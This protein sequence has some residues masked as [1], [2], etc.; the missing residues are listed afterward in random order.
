MTY[1]KWKIDKQLLKN[2]YLVLLGV[3][4]F[5]ILGQH[6]VINILHLPFSFMELYFIP[7]II[8][9]RKQVTKTIK[10]MGKV[11]IYTA[12]LY[13]LLVTGLLFGI[14]TTF[15]FN[16]L[17]AY[18]SILYLFFC[19]KYVQTGNFS[20]TPCTV[21]KVAI[22]AM[23]GEFI[24]ILFFATGKI[25]SSTNCVAIATAI[26]AAFLL[27]KYVVA[28]LCTAFG[29]ILS[30]TTGFRIGIVVVGVC[31]IEMFI[32]LLVSRGK[33]RK[34]T[35]VFSRALIVVAVIYTFALFI[36]NYEGVIRYVADITGMDYFAIFRVTERMRG[37]FM[38][39]SAIS[40]DTQRLEIM[41]YP[42]QRLI[43]IFP[44]G[45]IGESI[46]EYWLYIDV[47]ILYMYDLFGSIATIAIVLW[48]IGLLT[49]NLI[50]IRKLDTFKR[51]AIWLFPVMTLIFLINGT[52]MVTMF[53]AIETGVYLGILSR[54]KVCTNYNQRR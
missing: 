52:F 8:F 21:L 10:K 35:S 39:N 49:Y 19:F 41:T 47:P 30:I 26:I 3:F 13:M 54:K 2:I 20:E 1:T 12:L 44:R 14:G 18:R 38:R 37:L 53:Q 28:M 15:D 25:V 22:C 6:I 17:F 5:S 33:N 23:V 9:R 40:Q 27:E 46:E 16:I 50:N 34:E 4:G 24:Y 48:I 7:L 51:I 29:M 11:S 45:L 31:V 43:Q 36:S 32:F 42:I